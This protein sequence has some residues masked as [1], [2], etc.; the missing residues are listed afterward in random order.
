[1]YN[2]PE[3]RLSES[4]ENTN[5]INMSGLISRSKPKLG[6]ESYVNRKPNLISEPL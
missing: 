3:R 1:L 5:T 2:E 4:T 6:S